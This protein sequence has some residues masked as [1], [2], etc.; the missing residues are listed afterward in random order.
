MEILAYTLEYSLMER[1]NGSTHGTGYDYDTHVP[2]L[3]YGTGVK[4]GKET[5]DVHVIDIT[6]TVL[7]LLQL[8]H[9][10]LDGKP[11]VLN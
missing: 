7:N 9:D 11:R 5:S 4:T 6:P 10:E 1:Q 8:E 3:L 2:F